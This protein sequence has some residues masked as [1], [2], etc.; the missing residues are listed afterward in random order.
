MGWE[1]IKPKLIELSDPPSLPRWLLAGLL[2]LLVGVLFFI[3]HASGTVKQISV[4]NIW[5]LSLSPVGLWFI[6]FCIRGWLWGKKI[7]EYRFQQ[8]EIDHGQKQ[9]EA[10]A[11]RYLAILGAGILLPNNVNANNILLKD[12][13][14]PQFSLSCRISNDLVDEVALI[15]YCLGSVSEKIKSLPVELPL[16]VTLLTDSPELSESQLSFISAWQALFPDIFLSGELSVVNSLSMAWVEARLKQPVLA[17]DLVLVLQR[18]GADSY[19]DGLAALLLTS[20]DVAQKYQ[21]SYSARLLRPMALDMEQL[22]DDF[23]L[24][25]DTQVIA[26][27]TSRIF[28]DRQAWHGIF[29]ELLTAGAERKTIWSPEEIV[30]LEKFVG[31]PGPAGQWLLAVL[32]SEIAECSNASVL[33]LFENEIECFVSSVIP[34]NKNG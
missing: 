28:C 2:T 20:D 12:D 8:K 34:G 31:L 4:V 32:A 24:F 19:S 33:T 23:C 14:P 25:L 26:C 22:K 6:L 11:E 15:K 27:Q 17:V 21:L 16:N 7:N 29:A 10:W 13:S 1:R 18:Q 3:L 5:L 9:W 30:T